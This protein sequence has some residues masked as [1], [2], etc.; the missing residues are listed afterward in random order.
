MNRVSTEKVAK[1]LAQRMI[2]RGHQG[3][4][5]WL[6]AWCRRW[7]TKIA[8]D[9]EHNPLHCYKI[10]GDPK[11]PEA[12]VVIDNDNVPLALYR[13]WKYL[14]DGAR[15]VKGTPDGSVFWVD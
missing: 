4:I 1:Q 7:G 11:S 6:S 3:S 5:E 14:Q 12:V 8:K 10:V 9:T 2:D 13:E 15:T